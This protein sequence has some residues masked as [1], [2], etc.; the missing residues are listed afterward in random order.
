MIKPKLKECSV[1]H[2]LSVLWRSNPKMC[3]E[4]AQKEKV[5][6]SKFKYQTKVI[7]RVSTKQQKLN[8]AYM[9]LRNAFMKN[10]KLCEA[11]LI[12]LAGCTRKATECH[13]PNGR[14]K[15]LLDDSR[16]IALCHNCHAYIETHPT[17]AK[18]HGF[19]GNRL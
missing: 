8:A 16:F 10:H 18:E 15:Y 12:D 9:V 17:F 6:I 14:G 4:C 13:H 19:S 11:N 5:S 2:K 3:K 1:C 7:K